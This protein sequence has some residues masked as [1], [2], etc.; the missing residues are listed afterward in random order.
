VAAAQ[1]T[2]RAAVRS[3]AVASAHD[4]AEGGL[5]VAVAEC[6]LAGALGAAILLREIPGKPLR[7]LFGEGPGGFVV[8]GTEAALRVLG[9]EPI[10]TVGGEALEI[11]AGHARLSVSLERLRVAHRSL[12]AMF[13]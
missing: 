7:A 3:G 13:G 8:S 2:V 11:E 1:R 9:A 12:G 10:G 5:A 4:I 6:C